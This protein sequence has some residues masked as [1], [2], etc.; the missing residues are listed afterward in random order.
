VPSTHQILSDNSEEFE[1]QPLVSE[2][3]PFGPML[4]RSVARQ[5]LSLSESLSPRSASAFSG[6]GTVRVGED[7][8]GG[9]T[10]CGDAA[11]PPASARL[12][13]ALGVQ[14]RDTGRAAG[15]AEIFVNS[16][17][18]LSPAEGL[19]REW[20]DTAEVRE[21]SDEAE[22]R[23]YGSNDSIEL[24]AYGSRELRAYGSNESIELRKSLTVEAREMRERA[25]ELS[26][27]TPLLRGVDVRRDVP[28]DV[29]SDVR[30]GWSEA[31]AAKEVCS[32][33]RARPSRREVEDSDCVP[34]PDASRRSRL[35]RP[36]AVVCRAW[37]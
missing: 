31:L 14:E 10:G 5:P 20:R 23:A 29:P 19:L 12:E 21:T 27:E 11:C 26:D 13:A 24:R 15:V 8:E 3:H 16:T 36:L 6:D 28:S 35:K 18:R 17:V 32:A 37:L 2:Q 30:R 1:P 7:V 25:S 34:E 33:R 4:L 22:A 9:P